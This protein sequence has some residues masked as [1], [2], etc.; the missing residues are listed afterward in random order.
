MVDSYDVLEC[1]FIDEKM[2]YRA[3][4]PFIKGGGLFIQTG[5]SYD[6]GQDLTLSI[7]LPD[8]EDAYLVDGKVVWLT[9]KAAQGGKPVGVGVQLTGE[10]GEIVANKIET[11]LAGLLQSHQQTDTL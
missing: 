2:L 11:I 10:N 5:K 1:K 7:M 4:M 9:P 6:L 3:F 8:E